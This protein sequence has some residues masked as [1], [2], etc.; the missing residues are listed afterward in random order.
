[1]PELIP[2]IHPLL[3][4]APAHGAVAPRAFPTSRTSLVTSIGLHLVGVYMVGLIVFRADE[5]PPAI[6]S[7]D[8]VWLDARI[9]PP[10][11]PQAEAPRVIETPVPPTEVEPET[12]EPPAEPLSPPTRVVEQA[13]TVVMPVPPEPVVETESPSV[14]APSIDFEAESRRAASEVVEQRERDGNYLTFS[15]RDVAPERPMEE[16]EVPSIFDGSGASAPRGPTVG[17]LGQTKTRFGARVAEICNALSGGGFSLMGWGSFCG[18]P[19]DEPSGLFPEVMPEYLTLKPECVETRP[20]AA[21]LGEESEFPT[22]KCELVPRVEIERWAFPD[23]L[24]GTA[25][26]DS[27]P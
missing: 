21:D 19:D 12:R 5:L 3:E 2:A 17:R 7:A 4:A 15:I 9:V 16:P 6:P 27:V 25:P 23:S 8:F 22:I 10:T 14:V 24:D 20:L 13:P 11:A 26:P 1:M 18:D